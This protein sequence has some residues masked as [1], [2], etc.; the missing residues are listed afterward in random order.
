MENVNNF[1][2]EC[3]LTQLAS[4]CSLQLGFCGLWFQFHFYFWSLWSTLWICLGRSTLW[5]PV[6]NLGGD[7]FYGSALK[8]LGMLFGFW[9]KHAYPG[10]KPRSSFFFLFFLFRVIPA[11]Y[12]SSQAGGPLGAAAAS[13][14]HSNSSSKPHLRPLDPACS[15][16]RSLT[17]W[18]RPGV[19]PASSWI[20]VGL[21]N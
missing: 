11:A 7:T 12:R 21:L 18:V 14:C 6:W 9:C 4:G 13:L 5:W 1:F 16:T 19:E 10:P 8:V 2:L 3:S 20:I 15:N 17:H